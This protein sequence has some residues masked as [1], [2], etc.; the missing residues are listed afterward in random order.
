MGN[1]VHRLLDRFLAHRYR[2]VRAEPDNGRQSLDELTPARDI[3][4]DACP[5]VAGLGVV[6]WR[7][8]PLNS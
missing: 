5:D 6:E 2:W 7:V 4:P 8:T 3:P 1:P